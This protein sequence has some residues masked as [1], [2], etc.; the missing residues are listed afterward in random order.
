MTVKWKVK[1]FGPYSRSKE[2]ESWLNEIQQT[3]DIISVELHPFGTH[4]EILGTAKVN[5]TNGIDERGGDNA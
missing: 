5:V 1:T 2:V 3:G 4:G